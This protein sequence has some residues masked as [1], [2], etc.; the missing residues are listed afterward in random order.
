MGPY[1]N[2]HYN[3]IPAE[4]TTG[5]ITRN[6][7]NTQNQMRHKSKL[8]RK[9]EQYRNKRIK[10]LALDSEEYIKRRKQQDKCVVET[11]SNLKTTGQRA[12]SARPE[13]DTCTGTCQTTELDNQT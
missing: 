6:E 9:I 11:D 13:F 8:R 4:D 5:E 3:S 2:D 10:N 12:R 7:I 1:G